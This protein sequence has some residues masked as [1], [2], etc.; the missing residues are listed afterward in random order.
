MAIA[1]LFGGVLSALGYAA[2]RRL[3]TRRGDWDQVVEGYPPG[4]SHVF[5]APRR[6]SLPTV[7]LPP[8]N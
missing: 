3:A 5:G 2:L 1:A 7:R 4:L 6:P 8:K